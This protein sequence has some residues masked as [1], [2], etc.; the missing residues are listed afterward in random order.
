MQLNERSPEYLAV[1]KENSEIEH[2]VLL[3]DYKK[4]TARDRKE[5]FPVNFLI[6]SES[7]DEREKISNLVEYICGSDEA[8]DN[9]LEMLPSIY[10]ASF[11]TKDKVLNILPSLYEVK[12][13]SQTFPHA[14]KI[15]IEQ[16]KLSQL[17]TPKKEKQKSTPQPIQASKDSVSLSSPQIVTETFKIQD[18]E[19]EDLPSI[20]D[21]K[22]TKVRL[23]MKCKSHLSLLHPIRRNK[24]H[25]CN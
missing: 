21:V 1:T 14:N 2:E 5:I 19:A 20:H 7:D 22:Q 13:T 8:Q 10:E 11:K 18:K 17:I 9:A 3:N 15:T 4:K 12:E 24:S 16:E 23:Q 6:E 25:H